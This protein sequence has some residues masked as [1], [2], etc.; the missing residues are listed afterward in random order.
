MPLFSVRGCVISS[1]KTESGIGPNRA[2]YAAKPCE[3]ACG[4]AAPPVWN[5]GGKALSTNGFAYPKPGHQATAMRAMEQT[6]RGKRWS[7]WQIGLRHSQREVL[8][9]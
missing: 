6:Q 1:M 3:C 5:D 8:R 7:W 4:C 2:L 9:A